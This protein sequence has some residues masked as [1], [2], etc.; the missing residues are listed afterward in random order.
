MRGLVEV[1]AMMSNHETHGTYEMDEDKL[2]Y[3]EE[4]YQKATGLR[5]GLLVNF[6][7]YP[8]IE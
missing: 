7:H 5:L 6:C 4:S 8:K 1:K 2:L 3:R